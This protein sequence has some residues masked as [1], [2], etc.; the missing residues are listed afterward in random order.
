MRT[1]SPEFDQNDKDILK[2]E[3]PRQLPMQFQALEVVVRRLTT[4]T[5]SLFDILRPI[6]ADNREDTEDKSG[7]VK[8]ADSKVPLAQ[9]LSDYNKML[10]RIAGSLEK[11]AESIE[12]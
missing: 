8:E 7:N 4:I 11:L 9:E 1:H 5:D 6:A 2:T 12:L 10:N 3:I